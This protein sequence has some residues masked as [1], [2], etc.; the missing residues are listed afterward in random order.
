MYLSLKIWICIM[1][2]MDVWK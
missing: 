2:S 1:C